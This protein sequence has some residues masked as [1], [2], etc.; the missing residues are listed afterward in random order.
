MV[1]DDEP[2]KIRLIIESAPR[3]TF[4]FYFFA[5]EYNEAQDQLGPRSL[6][7]S[8]AETIRLGQIEADTTAE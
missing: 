4:P 5:K 7:P 6:I 8:T 1:D 2:I 3:A